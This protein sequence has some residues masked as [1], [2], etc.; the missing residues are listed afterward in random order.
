MELLSFPEPAQEHFERFVV[1]SNAMDEDP[2]RFDDIQERVRMLA[3]FQAPVGRSHHA[4]EA[5]HAGQQSKHL[6]DLLGKAIAASAR[7]V[8]RVGID[9]QEIAL[10]SCE[11]CN[12]GHCGRSVT[13]GV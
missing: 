1:G 7:P 8:L 10:G 12:F 3:Q 4:P 2:A 9:A 5:R 6:V 11:K 13:T